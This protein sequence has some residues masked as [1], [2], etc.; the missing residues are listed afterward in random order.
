MIWISN[1]IQASLCLC[2]EGPIHKHWNEGMLA[3]NCLRNVS[4]AASGF[5]KVVFLHKI[6]LVL[7]FRSVQLWETLSMFFIEVKNWNKII[8]E[9]PHSYSR[10]IT[11]PNNI[12][13]IKL[14]C[15]QIFRN[16][17]IICKHN[18]LR[19]SLY[20]RPHFNSN[21]KRTLFLTRQ[22]SY[23]LVHSFNKTVY[24]INIIL[25]WSSNFIDKLVR[26]AKS[27]AAIQFW[28]LCR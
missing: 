10:H 4:D 19:L 9:I 13:V 2:I 28:H 22:G 1:T 12:N 21:V 18:N 8:R 5:I 20:R 14:S 26:R 16:K 6:Q 15:D 11:Q 17:C 23:Y 27:L 24:R 7:I 3:W 25:C